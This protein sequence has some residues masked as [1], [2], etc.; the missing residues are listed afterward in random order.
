M[1]MIKYVGGRPLKY[2]NVAGTG[3]S[4]Q[5]G[6]SKSVS[7]SAA[8]KLVC[9]PDVWELDEGEDGEKAKQA[10]VKA[11]RAEGEKA[12]AEAKAKAEAE[13]KATAESDSRAGKTNTN[14]A[15]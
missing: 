1:P 15:K 10:K 6:E 14:P 2:D 7:Q 5:A 13:Q 3:L 9:Y 8:N 12:E 11:E 4:W